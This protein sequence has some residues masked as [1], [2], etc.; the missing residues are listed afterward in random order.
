[1]GRDKRL[2]FTLV[3]L[4]IVIVIIAILATITTIAFNGITER[5]RNTAKV[6]KVESIGKLLSL[7]HAANDEYPMGVNGTWCLTLDNLCT[8]YTGSKSLSDNTTLMTELSKFGIPPQDAGDATDIEHYGIN[9]IY[10]GSRTLNGNPSPVIITFWLDGINKKCSNTVGSMTS[11]TDG[12]GNNMV[13]ATRANGN[14]DGRTRCY[15]MF[16]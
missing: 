16:P 14:T 10:S 12:A 13:S 11:A 1:M 4:L 6:S 2:G 15:F 5:A 7:Y 3:E 8:T 9:Y